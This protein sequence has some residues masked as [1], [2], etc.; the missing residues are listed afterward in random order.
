MKRNCVS[1]QCGFTLMEML[2]ATS[3]V[4]MLSVVVVQLFLTTIRSNTKTELLKETKQS[5]NFVLSVIERMLRNAIS[6]TSVCD[7]T[8][9]NSVTIVNPNREST[10]FSCVESGGIVYIASNTDRMT[11]S[12]V[13]LGSSCDSLSPKIFTCDVSSL[14]LPSA[15]TISFQLKQKTS[16]GDTFETSASTFQTRVNLRNISE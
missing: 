4:A 9:Q 10:T 6:I 12:N 11:S 1:L 5:G 14:G 13:S 3:I 15:V 7:G 2:I 16:S 8:P